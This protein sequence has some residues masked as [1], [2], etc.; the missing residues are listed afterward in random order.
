MKKLLTLLI[1]VVIIAGLATLIQYIRAQKVLSEL[2]PTKDPALSSELP[3]QYFPFNGSYNSQ[4]DKTGR[5][6]AVCKCPDGSISTTRPGSKEC[7]C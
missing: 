7:D 3:I 4:G 1:A 2:N 5:K 6:S